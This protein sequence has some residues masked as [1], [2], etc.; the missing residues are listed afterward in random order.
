MGEILFRFVI[1]YFSMLFAMKLVGK[2]QIGE[3]QT[4]ELVAAF[5]LSELASFAVTNRKI[6][7]YY[8]LIPIFLMV[9]IEVLVSYFAL[10]IPIVKRVLEFSPSVLIRDGN[11]LEK[12]LRKN[13]VTLDEL[14][15][16]LRLNGYY[17]ISKVRFA[18]L[19]P[20]GQL[21]VV[22][23]SKNDSLSPEDIVLD[24]PEVGFTV[25][26]IND[27]KINYKALS[28]IGRNE[29]WLKRILNQEKIISEKEIFLLSSDYL[30]N[31]KITRKSL[32]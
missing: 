30:G 21:S 29:K 10:K 27:G 7:V 11:V 6:P 1:V 15:S 23:F 8:G 2:R 14:L 22:P 12:E 26:L 9:L 25:A 16:M 17:D 31:V 24:V 28:A 32:D 18:I 19:E 4:S 13:R 3:M 5:F 20:N